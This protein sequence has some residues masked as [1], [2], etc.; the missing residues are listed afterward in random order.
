MRILAHC[1]KRIQYLL[2]FSS[3]FLKRIVRK[4]K[5]GRHGHDHCLIFTYFLIKQA[6]NLTYRDLEEITGI[7]NSTFVKA[8][9]KF[10]ERKVLSFTL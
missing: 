2:S 1:P 4:K 6:T 3:P 9:K 7:D 5:H 8:R 10:K